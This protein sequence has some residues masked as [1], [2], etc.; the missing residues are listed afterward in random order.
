MP[1]T[2]LFVLFAWVLPLAQANYFIVT[3]PTAGTQWANGAANLVT[4]TKGV[5]D[6]I[7]AVDIEMSRLSQDGIT[8]VAKEVPTAPGALNIFIQDLPQ[9]DDYYLLFLNSTSGNMFGLSPKFSIGS[10]ANSTVTA[11]PSVATVTV[12]GAPNPTV[13]F[14]TTFPATA[15]GVA[16]PGWQALT[17][18]MPQMLATVGVVM[19]CL[20]GGAWTIL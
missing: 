19:M 13:P 11:N 10:S 3:A 1:T 12:S 14:A 4:W 6:G 2:L 17:H 16:M 9:A 8:Y 7:F 5:G 20:L 18:A 15:N